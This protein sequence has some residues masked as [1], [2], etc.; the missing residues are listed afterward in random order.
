[1]RVA[2]MVTCIIAMGSDKAQHVRDTG[3]DVVAPGDE[4]ESPCIHGGAEGPGGVRVLSCAVTVRDRRPAGEN[5]PYGVPG[6]RCA[7]G[8]STG[9]RDR[10]GASG[11][12]RLLS[13]EDD[14]EGT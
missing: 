10:D 6:G 4:R 8:T 14:G 7:A 11:C 2:L 1:M 13:R 12:R 9:V 5:L 3:A